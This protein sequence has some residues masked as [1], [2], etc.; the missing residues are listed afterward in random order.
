MTEMTDYLENALLNHT[1]REG[2]TTFTSP[3]TL[4][5]GLSTSS[6]IGDDGSNFTPPTWT[7]YARQGLDF[8]L[9]SGG[10]SSNTNQV[11][12]VHGGGGTFTIQAV[13]IFDASSGGNMLLFTPITNTPVSS[14]ETLRFPV[15]NIT[16][17]FQ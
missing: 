16:V 10:I 4:F 15:G 9:A 3:A 7:G 6:P 8:G 5:L 11:D 1:L 17:Q 14:G 2:A 13:A 12:F